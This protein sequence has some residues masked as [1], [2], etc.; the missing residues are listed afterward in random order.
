MLL[1][2]SKGNEKSFC[3]TSFCLADVSRKAAFQESAN[4]FPSSLLIIRSIWRSV[5]LP[6]KTIGTL[7]NVAHFIHFIYITMQEYKNTVQTLMTI[8]EHFIYKSLNC[9]TGLKEPRM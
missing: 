2:Q 4:L 9:R 1:K 5:L 6:T 7:Q 3:H 8:E